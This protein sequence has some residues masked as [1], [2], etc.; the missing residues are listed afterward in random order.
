MFIKMT[1]LKQLDVKSI[2]IMHEL[3][4]ELC[5]YSQYGICATRSAMS[6]EAC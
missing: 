6:Y 2:H 5:T 4:A 3:P 1:C